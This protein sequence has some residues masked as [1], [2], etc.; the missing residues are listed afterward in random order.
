VQY[1]IT[2]EQSL[3]TCW[4]A[5]EDANPTTLDDPL[6]SG[7]EVFIKQTM[8]YVDFYKSYSAKVVM[9]RSDG[10]LDVIP[11]DKTLPPL[12][13]VPVN[14][15]V[16]GTNIN[17]KNNEYCTVEFKNGDPTQYYVSSFIGGAGGA[18]LALKD[19]EVDCGTMTITAVANGVFTGTYVDGFGATTTIALNTAIPIKGKI[20]KGWTRWEVTNES[21]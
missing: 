3:L 15:P 5:D 6:R 21:E 9:Q 2:D 13:S 10:T 17:V 8:R 16:G 14:P 11:D 18:R 7:F 12:T 1:E 19:G 4:F 20:K